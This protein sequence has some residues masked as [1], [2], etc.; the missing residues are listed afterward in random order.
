MIPMPIHTLV[1]GTEGPLDN[2]FHKVKGQDMEVHVEA[3]SVFVTPV[4]SLHGAGFGRRDLWKEC[5][6]DSLTSLW[7]CSMTLGCEQKQL[8]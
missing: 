8:I 6:E 2:R 3:H 1:E 7:Q 4:H 5:L